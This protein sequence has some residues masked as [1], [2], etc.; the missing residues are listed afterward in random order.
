MTVE[1][2]F[3]QVDDVLT[4]VS[5]NPSRG[6]MNTAIRAN[7]DCFRIAPRNLGGGGNAVGF[8]CETVRYCLPS[9]VP[10]SSSLIF[11]SGS[12]GGFGLGFLAIL[13]TDGNGRTAYLFVLYRC[14][15]RK[16]LPALGRSETSL[17]HVGP[18]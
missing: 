7:V 16:F 6:N 3:A 11:G 17:L 13:F 14:Y 8:R 10:A 2:C 18:S 12:V 1:P 5:E 4:C 9:P 15:E